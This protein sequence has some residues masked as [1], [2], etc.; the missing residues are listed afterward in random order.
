MITS[1]GSSVFKEHEN[2]TSLFFSLDINLL[3]SGYG[4]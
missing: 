3:K 4:V 2:N 1:I